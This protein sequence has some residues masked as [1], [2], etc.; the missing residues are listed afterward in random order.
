MLNSKLIKIEGLKNKGK[1]ML[2]KEIIY[3]NN[4]T[5]EIALKAILK[6]KNMKIRM[7]TALMQ[8]VVTSLKLIILKHN[9]SSRNP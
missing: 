5:L 7:D 6:G 1:V 3:K 4:Q 8:I 9:I 2:L